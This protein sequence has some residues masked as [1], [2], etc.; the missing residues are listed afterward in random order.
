MSKVFAA[1][2]APKSIRRPKDLS[3]SFLMIWVIYFS[4]WMIA[5][6]TPQQNNK[7]FTIS[8]LD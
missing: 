2:H 6:N 7:N 4:F 5:Q 8:A 3:I 1:T